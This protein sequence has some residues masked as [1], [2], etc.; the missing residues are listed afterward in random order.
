MASRSS[1]NGHTVW[2]PLGDLRYDPEI[3]RK[4]NRGRA[5]AI[6][7]ALD[8]DAL[9]VIQVSERGDGL[10]VIDGQHRTEALKAFGFRPT[11]KVEC[12]VHRNLSRAAEAELM[13]KL[14]KTA[15]LRLIDDFRIAVVAQDGEAV[16]ITK[17]VESLG[18]K[19]DEHAGDGII[20]APKSLQAVYR[21][22]RS[23][24]QRENPAVLRTTLKTL[25]DAWG[26]THAALAGEVIQGVGL[27]FH[28]YGN[29]LDAADLTHR[30][31]G[32]PGGP[33]GLLGKG[34]T[35]RE[36]RGGTIARAVAAVIVDIYNKGRRT[37]KLPDWWAS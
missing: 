1:A 33:T 36:M 12:R 9:G 35:M 26:T 21:G 10:Y 16:A 27:V 2:I 34:R 31:A 5:D 4:L 30:L 7:S 13:R 28:R 18:L 37:Q 19:V 15:K 29:S 25:L 24:P 23:T 22:D 6:A 17:I 11:E 3:Q 8:L 14:N 32:M 20:A